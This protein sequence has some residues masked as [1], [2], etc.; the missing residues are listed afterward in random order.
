M[1]SE[2]R[3]VRFDKWCK[4][5]EYVELGEQDDPC[6]SCLFYGGN[7]NSEKPMFWEEKTKNK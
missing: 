7:E 2:E 3:I 6:Y 1:D 5:C 4:K